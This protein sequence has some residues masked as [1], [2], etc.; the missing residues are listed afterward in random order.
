MGTFKE[1]ITLESCGDRVLANHGY[2]KESEYL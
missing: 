1:E 2:I